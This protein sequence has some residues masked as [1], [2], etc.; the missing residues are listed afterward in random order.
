M[1]IK[2]KISSIYNLFSRSSKLTAL[3]SWLLVVGS[4]LMVLGKPLYAQDKENSEFKLAVGLYN[5]GMYDLAVEQFKN[6]INT[7]PNTS[8][9][10]ES[11]FYLG[12]TQLKLKRYD[13]ARVTF[14]NFA[15]TYVEH[16]KAPEAWLKVGDAFLALNNTR[17]AASAYERVKVF[18]PKSQLVPEALLKAGQLY[19]QLADRENAKKIFRAIIQEYPAA[20]SVLPARLAIGEM[21]AEEGQTELAE[22]E[23]RRVAESDAP[24][25]VKASALFSIGKLQ[26]LNCLFAEAE[27]TFKSVIVNNKKS[28]AATAAAFEMGKLAASGRDY[29]TAIDYFKKVSSDDSADDSLQAR[30]LLETGKLYQIQKEYSNARKSFDKLT[31]K[32]P[33]SVLAEQAILEAG[34]SSLLNEDYKDALRYFKKIISVHASPYSAPALLL[35][36]EASFALRQYSEACR[37]LLSYTEAFPDNIQTPSAL[38]RLAGIFE[39]NLQEYRK[40]INVYDQLTQKFPQTPLVVEAAIGIAACQEKAND[41]DGALKTYIDLQSRYPANDFSDSVS[42]KIEYIKNHRIKDRDAGIEKLARLMGEVLTDKNKSEL[43]FKLGE[44][45]FNDLKDYESAA[46]QFTS[47]IDG[48]LEEKQLFDAY[49]YR[50][51]SYHLLSEL[52]PEAIASAIEFYD[53]LLK[54]YPK[55][56]ANEDV[57]FYSYKLKSHEKN[58]AEVIGL[59]Q[60]YLSQYPSSLHWDQVLLELAN[61][62][63]MAQAPNDAISSLQLLVT[64]YPKSPFLPDA[65]FQLGNLYKLLKHPDSSELNWRKAITTDYIKTSTI[66]SLWNLADYYNV[67]RNYPDAINI[68]K[69]LVNDFYYTSISEKAASAIPELYIAN[70]EYDEA[71]QFYNDPLNKYLSDE[72]K[73]KNV[74][75]IYFSLAT[76]YEKMG[77]RQKAVKYYSEYLANDRKGVNASKAFYSLGTLSR[78]EGRLDNASSYFKQAVSLGDAGSMTSEIADLLFQTEQYGEAAKQY[79]QLAQANDSLKDKQ[80]FQ[81]R[82]IVS[83]LRDNRL[84]EAQKLINDFNKNYKDIENYKAEFEYE[85]GLLYYRKQDYTAAKKLFENVAD[86]YEE[87]RFGAWGNFYIGKISEVLNKLEDAAKKYESIL[88]KFP[89]SDVIPRV[90]LSLGNMH[91]NAERFEQSIRFYQ[92]IIK[93]P[94]K[95]G[96]ILSYAMNNLIEAYE[97]TKLY[98]DALKITRD[99]IERYPNDEG[100]VDKKIKLGTLYTKIG[101]YDQA[102]LHFQNLIPEA[103]SLLEAEIRYNIGEAYYYKGDYQQAILE[104]LKI[105]YLVTKQGKVNWTATS[106]Y[107]AGQSYE[108]MS[109]FSEAISMY[110]QVIDRPGINATFKAAA[111]KEINR[112]NSIIKKEP[113]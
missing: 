9:G 1:K 23:A 7:Y 92:E 94:T 25:E 4:L 17:E 24:P 54:K 106:L 108:K 12:T 19:R 67:K 98:D 113:R 8:N 28:S 86:D 68:L 78:T 77:E 91:F 39:I 66:H 16:P 35:A 38:I 99:Y 63:A 80:H 34:R 95:S 30:A 51:R 2:L 85:T 58:P 88:K 59:A 97:S 79:S 64:E 81:S 18:H 10:I 89:D 69:R 102:V 22:R 27:G 52:K 11:H 73:A 65:Y 105:P 100:I 83:T 48:G 31:S 62:S 90:L 46:K 104:F 47:A 45:Y 101:Y 15:L 74:N 60:E 36:A 49:Y 43:S 21:Y 13:E 20:A 110:Q 55:N 72:L 111:Q 53:A 33:K 70:A 107:M 41:F 6:F 75:Q 26:V 57:A 96:D 61:A 82:A 29:I 71:I 56:S 5:D 3:S 40:A 42:G 112:V 32:F 14:Q 109:K 50:A 93:S 87:T 84:A 37:Y 76:V 103:G 44:I